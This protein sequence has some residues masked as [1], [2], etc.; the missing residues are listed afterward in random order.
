MGVTYDAGALL[1]GER[2]DRDMWALHL[3]FLDEETIPTVPAPV[4][5]QAWRGG[6]RQASLARLLAACRVESM[7]DEAA[8]RVG[9]LAG[10]AKHNDVIDVFVVEGAIRRGDAVVTSDLD[11]LRRVARAGGRP[12]LPIEKI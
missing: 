12:R 9:V 8:R 6:P 2:N 5:A 4:V 3:G 11:D 1:A 7:D 10:R